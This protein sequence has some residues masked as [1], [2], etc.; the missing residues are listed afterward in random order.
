MLTIEHASDKVSQQ[1]SG[2]YALQVGY[3]IQRQCRLAK[4]VQGDAKFG[5]VQVTY[6]N[7]ALKKVSDTLIR[8]KEFPSFRDV[9]FMIER[10][11]Q[12]IFPQNSMDF[13]QSIVEKQAYKMIWQHIKQGFLNSANRRDSDLKRT[14]S[15]G[16]DLDLKVNY[17]NQILKDSQLDLRMKGDRAYISFF[18]EKT[19][20]HF[21]KFVSPPISINLYQN[22]SS[23]EAGFEILGFQYQQSTE[24]GLL[25]NFAGS[26]M[27]Q[28]KMF[29]ENENIKKGT[30]FYAEILDKIR[31]KQ[32][33]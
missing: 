21:S 19:R 22:G 3:D 7:N 23:Q 13:Q 32:E 4:K 5:S 8:C 2:G 6:S 24:A 27:Q 10:S 9:N 28:V 15:H 18:E 26:F 1:S 33:T 14:S 31:T 20:D 17:F 30:A 11:T 25:A 16:N 12:Y 29:G